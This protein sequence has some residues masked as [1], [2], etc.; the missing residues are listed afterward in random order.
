MKSKVFIIVLLMS[1]AIGF[2]LRYV[3]IDKN[4]SYWNDE[5][6][7][8]LYARALLLTGKTDLGN[9][10][11]NGIYQILLYYVTAVF[12]KIFGL[13]EFA[14]LLPSI[15]IGTITIAT[16][17]YITK[18]L[19]G[20]TQAYIVM[21]LVTFSQIQLAWSTQ[22][23]PYIWLSLFNVLVVYLSYQYT[24]QKKVMN[25]YLL[26]AVLVSFVGILFQPTA[27]MSLLIVICAFSLKVIMEKKY[28]YLIAGGV[29]ALLGLL[30]LGF[31]TRSNILPLIFRFNFSID[32]YKLFLGKNYFWLIFTAGIGVL[33]LWPKHRV[34][35]IILAGS[36]GLIFFLAAFKISSSYVRYSFPGFLLL[37]ILAA[38]GVVFIAHSAHRALP[39]K[40]PLW[41]L[42]TIIFMLVTVYPLYKGIITL[43]PQHYYSINADIKEN[44]IVDYKT[45]FEKIKKMKAKKK[46]VIVMDAWN[47]RVPWYLPG[48][49]FVF[50]AP[51]TK[52]AFNSV[53]GEKI[54]TNVSSFEKEK[55]KYPA[56]IVIVEN[57]PSQT[58]VELQT[59]VRQSLKP[60]FTQTTVPYN[61][62]PYDDWSISVFSWGL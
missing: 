29:V 40:V 12:F 23:R 21:F 30:A 35:A 19:L 16:A 18:K 2:Y 47:D 33:G 52:P 6:H 22:L 54:I 37:Y 5:S 38:Q 8:A 27:V 43:K 49:R 10:S 60:R 26:S 53:Y 55:K 51:D 28:H 15:F 59:H 24:R 3:G 46:N 7:A 9:T 56:G 1:T 45:A 4:L 17:G 50:L 36:T 48:Q 39:K 41:A 34:L 32:H 44:P 58:S 61:T 20:D 31:S 11:N 57:W 62:E 25:S 42:T 14:G 13:T